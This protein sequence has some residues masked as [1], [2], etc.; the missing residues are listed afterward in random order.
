MQNPKKVQIF[1]CAGY[2]VWCMI[3]IFRLLAGGLNL[4]ARC[5]S[6]IVFEFNFMT[7]SEVFPGC[8]E[9]SLCHYG[10]P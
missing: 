2:C 1:F 4:V 8:F 7:P 9:L 3:L 6:K 10:T 5:V